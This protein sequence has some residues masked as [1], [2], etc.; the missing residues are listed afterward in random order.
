M[1]FKLNTFLINTEYIISR[2]LI[3]LEQ[4][5]TYLNIFV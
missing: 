2:Y 5:L 4:N 3:M 1:Y